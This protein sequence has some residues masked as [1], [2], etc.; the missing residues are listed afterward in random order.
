[1]FSF[2]TAQE[3]EAPYHKVCAHLHRQHMH[4]RCRQHENGPGL[5]DSSHLLKKKTL[6]LQDQIQDFEIVEKTEMLVFS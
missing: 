3:G 2:V 6:G 5:E 1:M 4:D